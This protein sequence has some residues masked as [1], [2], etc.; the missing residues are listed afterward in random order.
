M[1]LCPLC[2]RPARRTAGYRRYNY[3]DCPHC[4]MKWTLPADFGHEAGEGEPQTAEQ[5]QERLAKMDA[6]TEY[7]WRTGQIL[8][9][10][11]NAYLRWREQEEA[12][13]HTLLG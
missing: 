4:G 5:A 13:I 10:H 2:Q 1:I 9:L 6:C 3:F 11:I 8:E 12:R 7:L